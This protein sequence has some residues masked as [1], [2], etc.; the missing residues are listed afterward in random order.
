MKLTQQNPLCP[1]R[2]FCPSSTVREKAYL[3]G[4]ATGGLRS[5]R[6]L[7]K[8]SL[9]SIRAQRLTIGR[10]RDTSDAPQVVQFASKLLEI[11]VSQTMIERADP[12]ELQLGIV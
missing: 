11:D 4:P 12:G 9:Y 5:H 6:R 10:E 7:F 3:P 2:T 8:S 1:D